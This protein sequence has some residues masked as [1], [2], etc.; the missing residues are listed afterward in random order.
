[1]GFFDFLKPKPKLPPE[2]V[3]KLKEINAIAFPGGQKQI[4]E[5]TSQLH[6]L[7][8]GRLNK[9]ESGK[10]LRGTKRLLIIAQDKSEARIIE[11][12]LRSTSGK[13]TQHEARLVY[14]F[15]TGTSG[16]T[17]TGGD[18][19]SAEKAVV[20]NATSSGIGVSAEYDYV[21]RV[22]GKRDVD[23][24][25]GM[26]MLRSQNGRDYDVLEIKMKDGSTRYFWFDIT[27]FY[28]KL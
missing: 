28:G 14:T 24:T 13:L 6:T 27:S 3:D 22:C 19:S 2:I 12:I 4:D 5:E 11:S 9:E 18:G 23:Y 26:Q 17:T 7:L 25:L 8:R 1:M 15:L 20:I 16:P 10:L 21:E